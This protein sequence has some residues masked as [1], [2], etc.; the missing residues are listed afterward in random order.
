MSSR[1]IASPARSVI[2]VLAGVLAGVLAASPSL[3]AGELLRLDSE[4]FEIYT[5]LPRRDAEDVARELE[6]AYAVF[7]QIFF[8]TERDPDFRALVYVILD[9]GLWAEF[10]GDRTEIRAFY[11]GRADRPLFASSLPREDPTP[12]SSTIHEI[13]HLFIDQLLPFRPFWV[14]EGLAE[15]LSTVEVDEDEVKLGKVPVARSAI[16]HRNPLLALDEVLGRTKEDSTDWTARETDFMYAQSWA[17]VHY[18][19]HGAKEPDRLGF[20]EYLRDLG[21][22]GAGDLSSH[23]DSDLRQ[24]SNGFRFYVKKGLYRFRAVAAPELTVIQ[25]VSTASLSA[26]ASR[27]ALAYLMV[28]SGEAT[29]AA[30]R[31][32]EPPVTALGV[33]ARAGTLTRAQHVQA[34]ELLDGTLGS[35][36]PDPYL[37]LEKSRLLARLKSPNREKRRAVLDRLVTQAPWLAAGLDERAQLALEEDAPET[38]LG[39]IR[40]AVA[41]RGGEASYYLTLGRAL[42]QSGNPAGARAVLTEAL[43]L[44]RSERTRRRMQSLAEEIEEHLARTSGQSKSLKSPAAG[45]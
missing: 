38:A 33:L 18:L 42:A 43:P 9:D 11:D 17:L 32:G 28:R 6:T 19:I 45:E 16:L 12:L 24:V 7:W 31:L 1:V 15:Y 21:R 39:L 3:D 20:E 30:E 26:A 23:L 41:L 5:D 2:I 27:E 10:R 8:R 29:R 14:S 4:H 36:S 22:S 13:A 35:E 37:L 34:L 40:R 25:D 44:A